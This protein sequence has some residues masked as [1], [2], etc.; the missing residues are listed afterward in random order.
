MNK[1]ILR[2]EKLTKDFDGVSALEQIDVLVR[3][4][5]IHGLI[6]PN[7]AGKSTFFNVK[8]SIEVGKLA[9][10]CVLDQDILTVDVHD[11]HNV[12]NLMTIVGGRIVILDLIKTTRKCRG[13]MQQGVSPRVLK[14]KLF[15]NMV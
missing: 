5:T 13:L 8:G 2:V 14:G 4:G 12:E 9:D 6:G 1:A 10:F 3:K 7:G 15:M 11:I